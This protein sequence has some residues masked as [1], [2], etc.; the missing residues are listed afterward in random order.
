MSSSAKYPAVHMNGTHPIHILAQM[1]Q[2]TL[3]AE[4][5][6]DYSYTNHVT[7]PVVNRTSLQEMDDLLVR[8]FAV[9]ISLDESVRYG[10]ICACILGWVIICRLYIA[11]L[12]VVFQ[13]C[14]VIHQ[15]IQSWRNQQ[16]QRTQAPGLAI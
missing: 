10:L 3:R 14:T 6:I 9:F 11:M 5:S 13:R 4:N 2:Q 12:M 15:R 1:H 7:E 8:G 16:I